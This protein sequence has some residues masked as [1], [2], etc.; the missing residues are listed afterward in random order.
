MLFQDIALQ[1]ESV[2]LTSKFS[3]EYT[4]FELF[5]LSTIIIH[6]KTPIDSTSFH[7]TY[8]FFFCPHFTGFVIRVF[9]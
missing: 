4:E 2:Y 8:S 5:R 9:W 1:K 7:V 3:C 6:G